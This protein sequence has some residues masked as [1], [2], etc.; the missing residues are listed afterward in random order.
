M[1]FPPHPREIDR[2]RFDS[3]LLRF[4]PARK[5]GPNLSMSS[6]EDRLSD[7]PHILVIDDDP[8]FQEIVAWMLGQLGYLAV[9][10]TSPIEIPQVTHGKKPA[11]ILLDWQLGSIDGTTLI[12]SLRQQFPRA[13]IVFATAFSS[14]EV[15][16]AAIKLGA[17]DFLV[18]PL[19]Q[20]KLTKE[21]E[22]LEGDWLEQQEALEAIV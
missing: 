5:I 16:A 4:F 17:F 22:Q 15:A 10:A 20:A 8:D 12:D 9:G 7:K 1:R 13:P 18:K 3:Q 21:L 6:Q 2:V 11:A 19:D 14:P